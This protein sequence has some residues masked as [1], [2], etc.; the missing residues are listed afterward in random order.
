MPITY[1]REKLNE[2]KR[3][4]K[5]YDREFYAVVQALKKWTHYLLSKEF[6]LYTDNHALQYIMQ[7]PKLSQKHIK[8]IE[9]LQRFTFVFKHISGQSNKIVDALSRR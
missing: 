6:I 9:Y 4:Y 8:W 3:K 5:T 1:F 2:A 7:Q